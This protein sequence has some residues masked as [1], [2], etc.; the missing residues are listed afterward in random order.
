[1]D[2]RSLLR[3]VDKPFLLSKISKST[4]L[5]I[6][7]PENQCSVFLS[8][9]HRMFPT[10]MQAS[11][12]LIR[13]KRSF[14]WFI[15]SYFLSHARLKITETKLECNN[16][17]AFYD[18]NMIKLNDLFSPSATPSW[19]SISNENIFVWN[20]KKAVTKSRPSDASQKTIVATLF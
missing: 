13:N 17:K 15:T 9:F 5:S 10:Q 6:S 12:T 11:W 14:F 4:R 7:F 19:F 18:P 2:S 1:M 16:K 8:R 3:F 20:Q